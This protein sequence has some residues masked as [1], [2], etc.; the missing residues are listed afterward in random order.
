MAISITK[1]ES[2]WV[3]GVPGS[4][5]SERDQHIVAE[6]TIAASGTAYISLPIRPFASIHV[7]LT[8]GDITGI[9]EV[10]NTDVDSNYTVDYDSTGIQRTALFSALS[11]SRAYSNIGIPAVKNARLKLT[12]TAGC[13]V[14][15]YIYAS[16][17]DG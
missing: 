10:N 15:I 5:N 12:S 6:G 3:S 13:T 8:S 11:T 14:A 7:I 16:R 1:Q 9:I 2:I 4:S 17:R